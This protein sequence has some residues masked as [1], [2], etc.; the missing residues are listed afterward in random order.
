MTSTAAAPTPILPAPTSKRGVREIGRVGRPPGRRTFPVVSLTLAR[1]GRVASDLQVERLA[2]AARGTTDCFV[3]CHGWLYDEDEARQ[4][5]ARFFA[6]LEP[7]LASLGERIVPLGVCLH[8]ASKPFAHGDS[9]RGRAVEGVW[10]SLQTSVVG[11]ASNGSTLE[12]MLQTLCGAEIAASPEEEAELDL[13][14][15]AL[16]AG[17]ARGV[18]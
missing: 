16:E 6:L 14:H 7:V 5:A 13:L 9:T 3:F 15:A 2:T 8:W 10:P 11:R 17:P 4:D 18:Q 1:D 12:R